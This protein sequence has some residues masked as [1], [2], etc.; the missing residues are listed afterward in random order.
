MTRNRLAHVP[1]T[2]GALKALLDRVD[3][4]QFPQENS[5]EGAAVIVT[6]VA[7]ADPTNPAKSAPASEL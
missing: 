2:A 3:P 5:P 4:K 6:G 7:P 1:I